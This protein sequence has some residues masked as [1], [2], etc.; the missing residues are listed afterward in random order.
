MRPHSPLKKLLRD[1]VDRAFDDLFRQ[2]IVAFSRPEEVLLIVGVNGSHP[3]RGVVQN[4][5]TGWDRLEVNRWKGNLPY[6]DI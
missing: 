4:V 6:I 1:P 5:A 2:F 3:D